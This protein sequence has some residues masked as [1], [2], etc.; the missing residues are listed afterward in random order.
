MPVAQGQ[1]FARYPEGVRPRLVFVVA[2]RKL[3]FF[4]I[5]FSWFSNNLVEWKI[6]RGWVG[7]GGELVRFQFSSLHQLKMLLIVCFLV[8]LVEDPSLFFD[9]DLHGLLLFTVGE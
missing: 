9:R 5:L 6:P 1:S 4:A 8:V 3:A 2:K 7:G